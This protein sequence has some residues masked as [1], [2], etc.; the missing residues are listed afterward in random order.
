[1][2]Q[3]NGLTIKYQE[4][5]DSLLIIKNLKNQNLVEMIF[6]IEM[7]EPKENALKQEKSEIIFYGE[8]IYLRHLLSKKYLTY[9]SR[10]GS[11]DLYFT[12]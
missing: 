6:I 12:T 1:M 11:V 3:K 8:K 2:I 4:I 10:T 7:V 5:E 9:Y